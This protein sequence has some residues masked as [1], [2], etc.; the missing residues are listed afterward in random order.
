[1]KLNCH[2]VGFEIDC[3]EAIITVELIEFVVKMLYW[4]HD[5]QCQSQPHGSL[6]SFYVK[7]SW[8]KHWQVMILSF[9]SRCHNKDILN[10]VIFEYKMSLLSE[11]H[12][13]KPYFIFKTNVM[14]W[15][16]RCHVSLM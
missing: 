4:P 3:H 13:H 15:L 5:S 8:Q 14:S 6:T 1:M 9:M 16:W 7:L 12:V 10:N 2:V 11:R